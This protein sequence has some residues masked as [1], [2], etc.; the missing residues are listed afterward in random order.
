MWGLHLFTFMVVFFSSGIAMEKKYWLIM[1]TSWFVSIRFLRWG[2]FS[3]NLCT[4][5]ISS[6]L[7]SCKILKII[8]AGLWRLAL[9][10]SIMIMKLPY[11]SLW[12]IPSPWKHVSHQQCYYDY[13]KI[14]P[15]CYLEPLTSDIQ[16]TNLS[17]IDNFGKYDIYFKKL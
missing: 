14:E 5:E 17:M 15:K 10:I 12:G 16:L 4:F 9:F 6:R 2:N 8:H 7:M 13:P 3:S 1:L 11:A